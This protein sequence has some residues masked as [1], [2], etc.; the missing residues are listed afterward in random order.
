MKAGDGYRF[1]TT[2]LT[3]D[4]QGYP[5]MSPEVQNQLVQRLVDK[6]TMNKEDII[7]IHEENTEDAEVIVVAYGITARVTRPAIKK[8]REKGIKIGFI[9]LITVWPFPELTDRS[10]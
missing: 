6:I 7:E 1:H 10:R 5:V 9:K 8:A 3:H 2:G 4:E